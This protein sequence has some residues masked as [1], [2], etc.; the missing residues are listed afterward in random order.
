MS[1]ANRPRAAG[2]VTQP[3][4][5]LPPVTADDIHAA[6]RRLTEAL[7]TRYLIVSP[8]KAARIRDAVPPGIELIE[9]DYLPDPDAAYLFTAPPGWKP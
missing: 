6:I 2:L 4:E 3:A 5:P 7:P 8:A 9:N 1:H